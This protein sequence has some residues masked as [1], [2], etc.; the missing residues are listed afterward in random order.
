MVDYITMS[1]LFQGWPV[2]GGGVPVNHCRTVEH[3]FFAVEVY[4]LQVKTIQVILPSF[5]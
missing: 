4:L 1:S 5:S 2:I 3:R